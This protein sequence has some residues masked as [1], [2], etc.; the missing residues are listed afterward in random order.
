M[1]DRHGLAPPSGWV[2]RWAALVGA[3]GRVLDVACG[4]GRHAR[5]FAA[6]GCAVVAVDRDAAALDTLAGAA[7]ISPVEADLE[8]DPWPFEP[9]S[10]DAVVVTNYLHRPLFAHLLAALRP[11]GVLIYETFMAGHAQFGRP[12]N[13]HFLLRPGELAEAVAGRLALVA[14]EQG[15]VRTPRPAAVQRLCAASRDP[16]T[17]YLD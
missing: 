17:I 1:K 11:S 9:A 7:R 6:R 5:H 12:A 3:G 10:F 2:V 4:A 16:V 13:P 15:L 8:R 14:F